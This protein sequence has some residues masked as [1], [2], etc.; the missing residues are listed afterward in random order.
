MNQ[1]HLS[2]S[3]P[4]YM[5]SAGRKGAAVRDEAAAGSF[6]LLLTDEDAA[7]GR[8]NFGTVRYKRF[9]GLWTMT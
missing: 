3:L 4:S 1:G 6:N 2:H 9:C 5:S 7:L 8:I